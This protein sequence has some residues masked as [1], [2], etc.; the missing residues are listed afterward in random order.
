M[1]NSVGAGPIWPAWR[2]PYIL[3]HMSLEG[4]VPS[5]DE[6]IFK[7]VFYFIMSGRNWTVKEI[8]EEKKKG[9][10][11]RMGVG[12]TPTVCTALG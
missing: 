3:P 6:K 11:K 5:K 9:K 4:H 2:D 12:A 1:V 8:E 10:G 7:R